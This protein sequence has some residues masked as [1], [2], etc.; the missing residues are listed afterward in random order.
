MEGNEQLVRLGAKIRE[1]REGK[2]L[3]VGELGKKILSTKERIERI[4]K[5]EIN[6]QYYTM[7]LIAEALGLSVAEL[8]EG[9]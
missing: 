7:V 9:I 8:A 2:G 1:L 3:T 6:I 4:E 5:E